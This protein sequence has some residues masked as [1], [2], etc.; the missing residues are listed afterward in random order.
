MRCNGTDEPKS[1]GAG[2][3]IDR[4]A[5]AQSRPALLRMR[6]EGGREWG[7]ESAGGRSL[8]LRMRVRSQLFGVAE[9]QEREL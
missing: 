4:P 3:S 5:H 1:T 9:F 8:R 7:A 6:R 2:G